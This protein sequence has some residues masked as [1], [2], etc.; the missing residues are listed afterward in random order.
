MP[1][2]IS[3]IDAN[4]NNDKNL[5]ENEKYERKI[6]AAVKTG[7]VDNPK[8]NSKDKLVGVLRKQIDD[9]ESPSDYTT[10]YSL[11]NGIVTNN[12]YKTLDPQSYGIPTIRS[13]LPAP[14]IRRMGD[15]ANYGDQSDAYGLINPSVYSNLGIFEDDFFKS[16]TQEEIRGIFDNIGVGMSH[17]TFLRVWSEA[18]K[19][20]SNGQVTCMLM[21]VV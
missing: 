18:E 15:N 21:L 4:E 9:Y 1:S 11:L 20:G 5:S 6:I 12:F 13:D 8:E 7:L 3:Q 16:R 19:L 17:E 10:S 14:R 2:G